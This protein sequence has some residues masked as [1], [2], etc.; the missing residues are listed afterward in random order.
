MFEYLM[1]PLLLRTYTGTL[2]HQS[3]Q[4]CIDHQIAY[5]KQKG[6]PW[7]ISESGFYVFDATM[8]YQYQA[9]GVPGLGFKRGLSEDL[10]ITPY[11]S[12]LAL[13]FRPQAVLQNIE[14]L[15]RLQMVGRYGFYEAVDYYPA[16]LGLGEDKAIVRS[17]MAHHQGMIMLALADVLQGKKMVERFHTDPRFIVWTCFCKSRCRKERL[18]NIL[19]KKKVRRCALCL[20]LS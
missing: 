17:Y 8:N 7:G 4:A 13:P 20:R 14:H 5:G 11:A 1:P 3:F 6:V 19:M 15:K 16:R 2:Q 9:F 18:C 12:L 10:V